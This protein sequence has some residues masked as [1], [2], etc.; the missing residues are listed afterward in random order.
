[1][2]SKYII[3]KKG[4]RLILS[5][6]KLYQ[7]YACKQLWCHARRLLEVRKR[8]TRR[9]NLEGLGVFQPPTVYRSRRHRCFRGGLLFFM[10][11]HGRLSTGVLSIVVSKAPPGVTRATK[12]LA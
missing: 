6:K 9:R 4:L 7:I 11:M 10:T 1:M 8:R 12:T 3:E 2:H 5:N